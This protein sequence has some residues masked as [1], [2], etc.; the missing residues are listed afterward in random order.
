MSNEPTNS[1]KDEIQD[2]EIR[3]SKKAVKTS[4]SDEDKYIALAAVDLNGGNVYRTAVAIGIP[5]STLRE[6]NDARHARAAE[7]AEHRKENR[8]DLAT[9]LEDK[10]HSVVESITPEVISKA[11][12]A[13]RGVFLGIGI[14][15][16]VKMRGQGL[17]PDPA[18]EICRLLNCNRAQLPKR[19]ELG[20]GEEIPEGFGPILDVQPNQEGAYEVE[21][22]VQSADPAI[23]EDSEQASTDADQLDSV[24]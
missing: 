3:E 12:L 18:A 7:F 5:A 21:N 2:L 8:G 15:K 17:E 4:Y 9:K 11:T 20:P 24:N 14:D 16:V 1:I 19:L 10:L 23:T 6:W 22:Q 13:Q